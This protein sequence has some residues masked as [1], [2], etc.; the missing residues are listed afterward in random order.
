MMFAMFNDDFAMVLRWFYD[1]FTMLLRCFYDGFTMLLRCFTMFD[2]GFRR[3]TM[4][5]P[6]MMVLG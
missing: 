3:C 2:D 5:L 6:V 1:A 4:V